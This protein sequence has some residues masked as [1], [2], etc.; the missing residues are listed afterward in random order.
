MSVAQT[1]EKIVTNAV[2][3]SGI[4]DPRGNSPLGVDRTIDLQLH[5]AQMDGLDIP[6]TMRS[7]GYKWIMNTEGFKSLYEFDRWEEGFRKQGLEVVA[8]SAYDI[9]GKPIKEMTAYWKRKF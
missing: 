1:I 7:M 9:N 8:V 3:Y 5:L 4:A 2:G 6:E